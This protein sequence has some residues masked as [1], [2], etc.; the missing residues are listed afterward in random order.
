MGETELMP[1]YLI[2]HF[3]TYDLFAQEISDFFL[4]V[5]KQKRGA[6]CVNKVL[7]ILK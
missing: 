7:M 2:F 3:Y 5:C 1:K 6:V 4:T